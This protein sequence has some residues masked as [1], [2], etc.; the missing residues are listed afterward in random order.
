QLT[1]TL[2]SKDAKLRGLL[3]SAPN[4]L[5]NFFNIYNPLTGALDGVFGLGMGNNII[6][7]LCGTMAANNRPGDTEADIEQCVDV[8]APVIKDVVVNFPP[9]LANPVIGRTATPNQIK[10][11]NDDVKRRA[12]E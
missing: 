3:H 4:Q 7:L 8:L 11:Q 12:K 1:G 10:Y 5:A 2:K 9:F 6:S